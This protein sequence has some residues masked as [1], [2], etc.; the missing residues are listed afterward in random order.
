M[1]N[2]KSNNQ[3]SIFTIS[4]TR[5]PLALAVSAALSASAWAQTDAIDKP[6][7]NN[8][9]EIMVVTA[10]FRSASLEK[11]PSSITVIDAQQIQDES[12]QH[13]EDVMN[14]IANFNWSGGSSRPKYFQIRGVGEQEQYQGAPNSS[15]GYIVDDID[16][17]GI[18]MVSSMYDLQQV[19]VLRG[20]QGTR[21]GANALAGLIY[22][23]S[24]D[25]TDV[26]EHGAEVSLGNDDLQT[27][28]GFS[29]GPLSDSGKLLYRVALQQHQQNGYRDNLYLN[30][31]DTNGRDEFT[32]RAKLRWYA[33]DDLQ[34]DLTLLHADFDNGYDVWSLTNDPTNTLSDQPGVD[35]QR[36]TGAGFK[37]TYSGAEQFEL[38]SL[39]SFANTDHHYSYDGD[40]ANS[41]YWASKQCE[42]GG[43]VSPCQYDYFWDKTG[44]R[45][46]L[47]QEFR[48]SSTDQGRIFADST[49]WL[50]GVYAMNLKEDNQLYSEYNTWP[51][52]VL[53]SE[54]EA[55]NYA[56]FGQ[57]D[58]DLGADYAL[59]MGLRVERR[60]SH[61]SDTNNDNFDPSETMWGGHIA[62]SK[63]LNESHNV[64]ARVARGYK[65]GGFN[66][67]LPVELNDKKEFDTETLYNYEIGLKSHWFEGLIDTNL[68]LFYMDRQD[69]QVAA[70]QQDPNKPQRFI[71]YTENAG[72]SNNY[73]AELDATWY[74][75][76][77][78]QFYS[79]LGWLQTA[80]G[81]YQY[82]DKYGTDVDLTGRDLAHSPHLTY[83][84]GGT[85]RA[86]SGW[87]ANLN[88]S[89]K[90]EFYYSD[91]NDS[92]SEPYT[93][94]NARLGYEAS[95]WSAYLWG[96]NLF[97]EEYGV[98]GFY[99]G[100]EP[101]NGWAEKQYIRYGDPRQ[102]GV[103]LNVK[104]M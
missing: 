38:T 12:A 73:G 27:F 94:V 64:Y 68:A 16:L 36:T 83:S 31:E 90:S 14:S 79:S 39:T 9:M 95:A 3:S 60:N 49:D 30:K 29:S 1:S 63:V 10:D 19:E 101:D 75:T 71:L 82:Q 74:A 33:T 13:F 51:D 45:K 99:F 72:S 80:Y 48:L 96:R 100:N 66:M 84:L 23:K 18:G 5:T 70:S 42:E 78:L 97:D 56:V 41:E 40:W 46:T 7:P 26:F 102:I 11:M 91:S 85:Y 104:F 58:T 81:N 67:T 52:E 93:V 21:Y 77:N 37:A 8:D 6:D 87:F 65:A 55:T 4:L 54:Y 17:S 53:D 62:L 50:L 86:N 92:R 2:K 35:S 69:Q 57:L 89:G 88:M 20:P 76:D 59:S 103:T 25:P 28:S 34:L 32:G 47:S 98:R 24:N 15:V 22:L 61:Y 43:N 44:Q